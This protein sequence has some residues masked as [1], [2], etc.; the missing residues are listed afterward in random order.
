MDPRWLGPLAELSREL[1]TDPGVQ[2]ALQRVADAALQLL[3][4]D[5]ASVRLCQPDG[6]LRVGARAGVGVDR[7]APS[8]KRGEGVIGWVAQTGRIARV[9]DSR[10]E[11]RFLERKRGFAV[12]SILSVPVAGPEGTLGVLSASSPA[13]HAFAADHEL[14]ATLLANAAA[15]VLCMAELREAAL[16][17]AQTRAYNRRYL[18]P[19]LREELERA[20]RSGDALSVLLLDLDHFKRVNDEHGHAAGDAVLSAFADLVRSC[21]RSVDVLVRRGGEEFVLLLPATGLVAARAVAERIRQCL[22]GRTLEPRSGVRLTQTVSIGVAGWDREEDADALEERADRAMYD[23][24]RRGRNRVALS[25][26]V[27]RRRAG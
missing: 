4:A 22:A 9:S 10:Q 26:P 25:A 3:G 2:P 11:P 6:Q 8:F 27:V 14:L 23:A 21:V 5:H 18:A 15:Q 20:R 1:L 12:G 24:K 17:D 13:H 7:P 19:R 16:T